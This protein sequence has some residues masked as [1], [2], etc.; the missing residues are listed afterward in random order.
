MA[1]FTRKYEFIYYH[2]HVENIGPDNNFEY[3]LK[4]PSTKYRW[5]MSDTCYIDEVGS[6]LDDLQKTEWDAYI[7]NGG[8]GTR[9][10]Y[11]PKEKKIYKDSISLMSDI[12]WHLTW[13]SCMIYNEWMINVM[14]FSRYRDSC[15]N[16]TALMF[17]PL[18]NKKCNVGFNAEFRVQ[19]LIVQ[20]ESGWLYHVF[21]I[22]YRQWYL[23]IMSLPIYYPYEVKMKCIYD[24]ANKAALL[25]FYFHVKRRGEGKW[26]LHDVIKNKQFIKDVDGEYYWLIIMGLSPQIV[27]KWITKTIDVI[28]HLLK[29]NN[30]IRMI[31]KRMLNYYI[32][33]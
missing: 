12:G 9:H 23:T 16:Q 33:K 10:L 13:I 21:D 3:V 5:L 7:L 15:F 28:M 1:G 32:T 11:L 24:N 30:N 18:A 31:G 25:G 22:M 29:K 2:R 17:D 27:A 6:I 14:D 8:D 19:N 20:K 26:N 4:M